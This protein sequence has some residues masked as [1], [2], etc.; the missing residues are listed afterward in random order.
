MDSKIATPLSKDKDQTILIIDSDY[1]C[2]VYIK[3]AL[4][5]H[6]YRVE[7]ANSAAQ[8]FETLEKVDC[9]GVFIEQVLSDGDGIKVAAKIREKMGKDFPIIG[10]S[11][12]ALETIKSRYGAQLDVFTDICIKPPSY[13][14]FLE[15]LHHFKSKEAS[16]VVDAFSHIMNDYR[17]SIPNRLELF[18]ELINEIRKNPREETLKELRLQVHKLAGHAGLYGY[19]NVGIICKELDEIIVS[20]VDDINKIRNDEN[21]VSKCQAALTQIKEDYVVNPN[22][23]VGS[24]TEKITNKT[25]VVGVIGLGY[26]GLS[27][28]DAFGLGGF[29]LVGYD[30]DHGKVEMLRHKES[31]LNFLNMNR[32][33]ELM[34]RGSCEFSSDP[35][36]LENADVIIISVST[37]VDKYN[38]PNLTNLRSAFDVVAKYHKKQQL[39][40]LQSS[41]YP[42]TTREELLPVLLKSNLQLGIDF[43][44]AHA[45]EIADIG[46]EK[47]NF[48]EVPR[49]VSGITPAC[50]KMVSLLYHTIGCPIVPCS[51]T[52]VAEAA[53]LLQNSFRL[54]NISFINEMKVL[55]SS[56]GIDIWEV[57]ET[58]SSKPFGFMPFY[59]S[60]GIGGDCIPIAP[61]YL[62]WRAKVKGGPTTLLEDAGRVDDSMP[63]Y[64]INKL[65]EGLNLRKKTIRDSKILVLGVGYKKDV[66]DIRESAAL[67]IIPI[68]NTLLAKVYYNDPYVGAISDFP[69]YPDL[70]MTSVLLDYNSLDLY[71]AVMVLTDHSC[72]DWEK[73]I[74]NSD[75]VIDTRNVSANIVDTKKV[76]KA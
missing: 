29:P 16:L 3:E 52:E 14:V 70:K 48:F 61:R 59:P 10:M 44:L 73:I 11:T 30:N 47:F 5:H 66:N 71:D 49:I 74:K 41:T 32:L 6:G 20:N 64:V 38:T 34:D 51:S 21:F 13:G 24:L 7:I 60:P 45:P 36:V 2:C 50:L 4:V 27:L 53:K 72:Y 19:E 76:I 58:A 37:T 22:I 54:I 15:L 65:I 12:T 46:N 17:S 56:M 68:L 75:L 25:A 35:S 26:I 57:V 63:H 33:F 69:G 28:L 42:G 62:V 39:I 31:Y 1:D 55:F 43:Y 9:N 67:K 23:E 18:Q 8:A 40:I